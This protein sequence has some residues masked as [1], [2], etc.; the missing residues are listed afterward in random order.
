[1]T[2]RMWSEDKKGLA[3]L[4]VIA[5]IINAK[6]IAEASARR[7][8]SISIEENDFEGKRRNLRLPLCTCIHTDHGPEERFPD[9]QV[10][11]LVS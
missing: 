5:L 6:V 3:D 7:R 10:I 8:N 2:R 1:M 11:Y 9:A 4:L